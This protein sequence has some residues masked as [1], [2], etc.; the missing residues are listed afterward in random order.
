[1]GRDIKEHEVDT[2]QDGLDPSIKAKDVYT[3]DALTL[4]SA[5]AMFF[6]LENKLKV[7]GTLN[8]NEMSML[9]RARNWWTNLGTRQ[10]D[11]MY[12]IAFRYA[13]GH[14]E[15]ATRILG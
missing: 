13:Y 9:I 11:V 2:L 5:T 15:E 10:R 12:E 14:L 4:M 8:A 7:I 6:S 3:K 1:M